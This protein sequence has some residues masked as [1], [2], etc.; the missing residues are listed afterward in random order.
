MT[1]PSSAELTRARVAR[2]AVAILLVVAGLVAYSFRPTK[3]S[4]G[5]RREP[6][7]PML[8]V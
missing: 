4:L 8:V 2:R 5:L 6:L 3:P 7:M 1:L